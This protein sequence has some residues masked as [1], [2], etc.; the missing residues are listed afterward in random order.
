MTRCD[1]RFALCVCTGNVMNQAIAIALATPAKNRTVKQP[2]GF[3]RLPWLLVTLCTLCAAFVLSNLIPTL[4]LL[5]SVLGATCGTMLTFVIPIACAL[6]LLPRDMSAGVCVWH[7]SLCACVC[8][9]HCILCQCGVVLRGIV[10]FHCG[11]ALWEAV[12]G[13]SVRYCVEYHCGKRCAV[14]LHV[15]HCILKC[16]VGT[17]VASIL[18]DKCNASCEMHLSC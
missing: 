14:W 11:S 6:K 13:V 12:Q 1:F 5:I 15:R 3:P 16:L 18:S 4:G 10:L 9:W 7:G 2:A 8:V 17:C